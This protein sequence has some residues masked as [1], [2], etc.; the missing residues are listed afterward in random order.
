MMGV[1]YVF[2]GAMVVAGGCWLQMW[3]DHRWQ[4][5]WE[6]RVRPRAGI[7]AVTDRD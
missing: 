5:V 1:L 4:K 3:I 7:P 2:G 6:A